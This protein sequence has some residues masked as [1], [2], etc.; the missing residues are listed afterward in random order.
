MPEPSASGPR[1]PAW[2]RSRLNSSIVYLKETAAKPAW[3]SSYTILK[4]SV[5][6]SIRPIS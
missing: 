5:L 2:V 3:N 4:I 6:P 1:L